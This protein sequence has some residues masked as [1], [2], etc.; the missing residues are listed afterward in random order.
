MFP[1]QLIIRPQGNQLT[2]HM[3]PIACGIFSDREIPVGLCGIPFLLLRAHS[4]YVGPEFYPHQQNLAPSKATLFH[5]E[6]WPAGCGWWWRAATSTCRD[7]RGLH[8]PPSNHSETQPTSKPT[9]AASGT[10]PTGRSLL[11]EWRRPVATYNPLRHRESSWAVRQG[12]PCHHP[13]C[14]W[15][16]PP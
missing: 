10:R 6:L 16:L 8:C 3:A 11:S 14:G 1:N 15:P 2:A 9:T 5:R 7:G 12:G 4:E 13:V